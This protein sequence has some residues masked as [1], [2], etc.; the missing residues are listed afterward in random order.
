MEECDLVIVGAGKYISVL[1]A[2]ETR[3]NVKRNRVAWSR[4]RKDLS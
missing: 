2:L 1:S 4:Y 3:N